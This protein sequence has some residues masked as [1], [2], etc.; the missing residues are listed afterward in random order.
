[1]KPLLQRILVLIFICFFGS[2]FRFL[3]AQNRVFAVDSLTNVIDGNSPPFNLVLP[4]DTLLFENGRHDF[5]LL[6]NFTGELNNP[7]VIIN[8]GGMVTINTNHYYGISIRNCRYIKFTGTGDVNHFYSFRIERVENGGGIGI[9]EGSSDFEID[10]VSIENCHGAGI[11]AKT[12][13]DCTFINTREKFTQFNTIIHDTYIAAT[14]YEGM[15]IGSTKYFGQTVNC[16]GRDT[17]LLPSLLKGIRIF[18]NI[19]KY[20]GWDGIQVSSA[21]SDCNV[22]DNLVMFDSQDEYNN[23]MSGIMLGGGS[24]CNC[25]NNYI[26]NGKGNGIE[27]HGLGGNRIF[28]NI[29]IDAGRSYFPSDSTQMR[30]GIFI[31]DVSM[32]TDSSVYILHN[33]IINPK[34]DGIRFS[35]VKSRNNLVASNA[36]INPGNFDFYENGNTSFKGIDS[37]LMLT[38][39]SIDVSSKNN[40]Y[41]RTDTD[42]GFSDNEYTLLAGSP[43]IDSGYFD[44]KGI[45]S[46]Y[47]S[48]PR[49]Y[50]LNPDI[51][52]V[53][54]NPEYLGIADQNPFFETKPLLYPNPVSTLLNINYRSYSCTK[55][56]FIV[57][58]LHG[59]RIIS[60]SCFPK[61]GEINSIKVDVGYFDAGLYIY[62]LS[63]DQHIV[64]GKFIKM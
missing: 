39:H 26:G 38:D 25:Y 63:S 56:T 15:Y 53:E 4:G 57:Y 42:A 29:I 20:S 44:L 30:H 3:C 46:D 59:N 1:M 61:S 31:S 21:S 12:D 58:D 35:S 11:S 33:N 10:H 34:S 19:I 37:Y 24:K 17:L 36:I 41:S 16:E 27:N 22:F 5:I 45:D 48:H 28:N 51:G 14:S 54:Y 32:L 43:L 40:F 49:L 60:R 23:Q 8:G 18:N 64:T 6:R 2:G 7:I 13:P 9:G 50:G 47:Y 55:V 52:A 62:Q